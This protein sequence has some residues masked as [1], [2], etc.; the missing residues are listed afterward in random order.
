MA[1]QKI[2]QMTTTQF[3]SGG[4]LFETVQNN[5]TRSVYSSAAK[6]YYNDPVE[7]LI[8]NPEF[9]INQEV[10]TL[11][12]HSSDVY[13]RDQWKAGSSGCT[14]SLNN[15]E[16]TITAGSII[17][18]I[19]DVSIPS[20]SYYTISWEGTSQ[21]KID[22][23]SV[24]DSPYTFNVSSGTHVEVEFTTGTLKHPVL[25]KGQLQRRFTRPDFGLELLKCQRYWCKSYNYTVAP[26]SISFLG[27][28]IEL[29][30]R[31]Y[32]D[33]AGTRFPVIMRINP[34]IIIYSPNSGAVNYVYN[35]AG[36]KVV[37]NIYY[38]SEVGIVHIG[39]TSGDVNSNAVWHYTADA[40][41]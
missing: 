5:N 19:E 2:T 12:S 22:G 10:I 8:I 20:G 15:N 32:V 6:I 18:P 28:I 7:N 14:A 17:Q 4:E 30:V 41:I 1:T 23:G 16:L 29:A 38:P 34:T 27:S 11:G 9:N 25:V 36:D 13:F 3:L 24:Q 21:V 33:T 40:R 26:G 39:I 37:S 35:G 31:N